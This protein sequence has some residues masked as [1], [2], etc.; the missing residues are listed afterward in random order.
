MHIE[1]DQIGLLRANCRDRLQPVLTLTHDFYVGG[2][3]QQRDQ[4]LA[5]QRFVIYHE[6]TQ[7]SSDHTS[8]TV[9]RLPSM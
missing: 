8:A 3:G 9:A 6:N 4:P 2:V 5:R 7:R 1:E